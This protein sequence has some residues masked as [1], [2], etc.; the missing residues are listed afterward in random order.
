[1]EII[2]GYSCIIRIKYTKNHKLIQSG[3]IPRPQY[4]LPQLVSIS[5]KNNKIWRRNCLWLIYASHLIQKILIF[6]LPEK[7][8]AGAGKYNTE[9]PRSTNYHHS[10]L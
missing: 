6:S 10:V 7:N 5:S 2:T 8:V 9:L 4:Q 3:E 1:M